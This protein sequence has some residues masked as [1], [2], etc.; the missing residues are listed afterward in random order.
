MILLFILFLVILILLVFSSVYAVRAAAELAKT[1]YKS[2]ANLDRAYKW[3]VYASIIGWIGV[4]L[5]IFGIILSLYLGS[6]PGGILSFFTLAVIISLGVLCALG[7]D[8]I[9]N[10]TKKGSNIDTAK[11]YVMIS[12]LTSIIGGMVL[13]GLFIYI[14]FIKSKKIIYVDPYGKIINDSGNPKIL[15]SNN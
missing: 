10:S 12:T 6:S 15:E 1:D 3:L 14:S 13:S 7:W 2:N 11:K 8:D 4:G 9:N 5:V